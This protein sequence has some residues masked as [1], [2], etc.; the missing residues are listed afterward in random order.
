MTL[1]RL[2]VLYE[3]V[4]LP[5]FALPTALAE[6]YGGSLGFDEPRL[7]ANFV[8]TVDG[9]VAIPSVPSSNKLIAAGNAS[10]RLVMGILRAC[11]DA[12]VIGSGTLAA[13]PRSV[14][15]PEQAYPDA[16]AAFVELRSLIG[17]PPRP[18]LVILS[19]RGVVDAAHPSFEAGAVVLTTDSGAA[20]L[21]GTLPAASEVVSIGAGAELDARELVAAL[22]ARGHRLI[23]SEGGARSLAPLLAAGVVDELFLTISPLLV[24]RTPGGPRLGLVEGADLLSGGPVEARLLGVRRDGDH[25]FLRYGLGRPGQDRLPS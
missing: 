23:L 12:L 6:A 17:R 20:R 9:V 4:G 5:A 18:E 14:W 7:F 24:G 11:A 8:A 10:D 19:A 25:L 15:T 1:P 13:S 3:A 2:D 16:D 21:E 22:E